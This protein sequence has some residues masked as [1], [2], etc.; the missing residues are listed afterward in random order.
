MSRCTIDLQIVQRNKLPP[1][2]AGIFPHSIIGAIRH[3]AVT[4][5]RPSEQSPGTNSEISTVRENIY[6]R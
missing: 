3:S 2:V 1:I 6:P 4:N 5:D